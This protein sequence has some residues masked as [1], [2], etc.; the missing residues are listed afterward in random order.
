MWITSSTRR[1]NS[2]GLSSSGGGGMF[3]SAKWLSKWVFSL[4]FYIGSFLFFLKEVNLFTICLPSIF[5]H[6]LFWQLYWCYPLF[7]C[8]VRSSISSFDSWWFSISPFLVR[9]FVQLHHLYNQLVQCLLFP[10]FLL[11]SQYNSRTYVFYISLYNW[12]Y[13]LIH[14]IFL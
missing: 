10:A 3:R 6:H 14:L 5:L 4:Q 7:P 13:G 2:C 9:E 8:C 11:L 12:C 1:W